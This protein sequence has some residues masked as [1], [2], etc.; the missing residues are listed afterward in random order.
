MS[1]TR[2]H[3]LQK[4]ATSGLQPVDVTSVSTI[5]FLIEIKF[6]REKSLFQNSNDQQNLT[7]VVISYEIYETCRRLVS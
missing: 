4:M 2:K 7:F 3:M 5:R 1:V 6:E